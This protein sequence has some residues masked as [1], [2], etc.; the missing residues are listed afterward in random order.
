MWS[1]WGGIVD[2]VVNTSSQFIWA[3]ITAGFFTPIAR[4]DL[5]KADFIAESFPIEVDTVKMSTEVLLSECLEVRN[6]L[7]EFGLGP[8]LEWE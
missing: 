6:E 2:E 8:L 1:S 3:L 7:G 5:M 4:A